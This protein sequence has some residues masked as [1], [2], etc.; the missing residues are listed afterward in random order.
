MRGLLFCFSFGQN[1]HF[2]PDR[3]VRRK[4]A[5][6]FCNS[7]PKRTSNPQWLS[8]EEI[9][10]KISVI[11]R[12]NGTLIRSGSVRRKIFPKLSSKRLPADQVPTVRARKISARHYTKRPV[13]LRKAKGMKIFF[14]RGLNFR[15]SR[16]LPVKTENFLAD[17]GLLLAL[18][19]PTCEG[20]KF[21]NLFPKRLSHPQWFDGGG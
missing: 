4:L 7:P 14:L 21:S 20:R 2:C 15:V 9:C 12:Q 8:E 6:N 1:A 5:K 18:P 3:S 16:G 13:F 10:R 19:W 11:L 17:G